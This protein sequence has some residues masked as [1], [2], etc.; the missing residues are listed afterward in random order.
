MKNKR[1]R[2]NENQLDR[3]IL[4]EYMDKY[5][6]MPLY[7]YFNMSD[8]EKEEDIIYHGWYYL[9]DWI[10]YYYE[11]DIDYFEKKYNLTPEDL[12]DI[13]LALNEGDSTIAETIIHGRFQAI[14][15]D[16]AQWLMRKYESNY[17][18]YDKGPS[19]MYMDSA[20]QIH[21]EWLIHFSNHADQIS[22][23][24]FK[25]GTNDFENLAYSNAGETDGKWEGYDFAYALDD[26]G[27]YAFSSRGMYG[28]I[29]KYGRE[30]V[31]FRASG[32]KLWHHGDQEPQ[33]IFY[34]P[35][36]KDIIY[37][38][39]DEE[40]HEWCIASRFDPSKMLYHNDDIDKVIDWVL[41]NYDQYRKH[42]SDY[43]Y[44]KNYDTN[45]HNY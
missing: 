41:H 10:N 12:D 6:L 45:Y 24:G 34:G 22:W 2:I 7:R 29:P 16:F 44:N 26:V 15:H 19:W 40:I 11:D 14:K 3:L 20:E 30:A 27:R 8:E 38:R 13:Q 42:L 31:I 39:Y 9:E 21:N 18:F 35:S 32:V 4:L 33:V 23:R 1:I 17:G 28:R 25:H 43:R 37:L 36:A 5:H